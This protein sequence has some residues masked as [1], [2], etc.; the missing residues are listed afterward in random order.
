MYIYIKQKNINGIRCLCIV[1]G[2]GSVL[3]AQCPPVHDD[4]FTN[5]LKLLIDKGYIL[6]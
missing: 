4:R 3:Y 1:T 2:D 5:E 6:A